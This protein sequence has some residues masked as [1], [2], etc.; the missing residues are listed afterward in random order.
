[1][2]TQIIREAV[3]TSRGGLDGADDAAVMIIWKSLTKETRQ[4]YLQKI[5]KKGKE[6]QNANST[7]TVQDVSLRPE[8]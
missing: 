7:G 5:S 4:E 3:L 6:K 2:D 1:M 8:K